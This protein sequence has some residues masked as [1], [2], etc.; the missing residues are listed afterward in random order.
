MREVS[1]SPGIALCHQQVPVGALPTSKNPTRRLR[2]R[3]S[4][5]GRTQPR[6]RDNFDVFPRPGSASTASYTFVLPHVGIPEYRPFAQPMS[7]EHAS[8]RDTN[9]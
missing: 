4:T 1:I 8:G 6:E 5:L 3:G 7:N 2:A 9:A